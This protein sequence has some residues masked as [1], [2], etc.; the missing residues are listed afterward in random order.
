MPCE[1]A[2]G[3]CIPAQNS[4]NGGV[5]YTEDLQDLITH[6]VGHWLWLED[7]TSKDGYNLTMNSGLDQPDRG[8]TDRRRVTLG[9]GD[10]LGARSAYPC[11]CGFP[12]I[13][14]P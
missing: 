4:P 9:L 2:D 10:I 7:L 8:F 11:E 12:P 1:Q 14:D 6:E 3:S 13:Y 5:S